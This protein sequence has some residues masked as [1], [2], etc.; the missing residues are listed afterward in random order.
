MSATLQFEWYGLGDD[1][2]GPWPEPGN[3][4]TQAAPPVNSL[5]EFEEDTVSTLSVAENAPPNTNIGDPV[6]ASDPESDALTYSLSGTDAT[7]FSVGTSTGQIRIGASTALD[8]ESSADSGSNNVYDVTVRVTDGKLFTNE[9]AQRNELRGVV[10]TNLQLYGGEPIETAAGRG[11]FVS[12]GHRAQGFAHA[13]SLAMNVSNPERARRVEDGPYGGTALMI[14]DE[15]A[16]ESMTVPVQTNGASWGAV[17]LSDLSLAQA[18]F[19]L[20]HSKLWLPCS[21]SALDV[22]VAPLDKIAT[23]G[24]VHRDIMGPRPRGPFDKIT[25]TPTA[26]YPSL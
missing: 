12:L 16:G 7:L 11:H 17:R 3:A 15:L 10:Y 26:T 19:A 21:H 2:R 25:P 8:H 6:A 1:K 4:A 9:P 14:G 23:L 22:K 5:P 20:A 13:G 18:A 24:M